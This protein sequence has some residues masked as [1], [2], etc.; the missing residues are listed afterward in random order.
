MWVFELVKEFLPALFAILLILI[1]GL[2]P[3]DVVLSGFSSS[4]FF[5][6]MSILGLGTVIVLSGLSFRFLLW[7]L[8]YLCIWM[9]LP[10]NICGQIIRY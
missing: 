1:L 3:T 6:A 8:R 7:L 9:G 2:A 10:S 4:G 5:M